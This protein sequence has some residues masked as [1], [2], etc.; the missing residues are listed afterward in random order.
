MS[1]VLRSVITKT[2]PAV[3][4]NITQ[5][6]NV[7]SGP[8]K[9]QISITEKVGVG[10]LMCAVVVAPASWILMNIPNYKKRDD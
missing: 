4:S 1:G 6:A 10:V 5:K 8:P 2:A 7:M 9:H 3:R